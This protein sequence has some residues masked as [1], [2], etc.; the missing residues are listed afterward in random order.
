MSATSTVALVP[1]R[2]PGLGKTRLAP[3]LDPDLRA[4][5]AGA[6]LA[7]VARALADSPVDR[8]LVVAGGGA[9][10]AAG[11]ALGLDV[12]T[13]PPHVATLDDALDAAVA[14]VGPARETLVVAADL[15][16]LTSADVMAVL[17]LGAPV[18]VAPTHDGGTGGLLRC[19][20]DVLRTAYGPRS[21]ARH[22]AAARAGGIRALSVDAPGFAADVDTVADVAALRQGPVGPATARWLASV[23]VGRLVG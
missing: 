11:A 17:D 10:A 9:A 16:R 22:L 2:S 12:V 18:V 3:A 5:L 19:P 4:G 14:A 20:P 21:A 6:M 8:I 23:D 15:P 1:L 7:D 13:D